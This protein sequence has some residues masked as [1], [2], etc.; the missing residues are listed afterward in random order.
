MCMCIHALFLSC[1]HTHTRQKGTPSEHSH[2]SATML[3]TLQ[4]FNDK[5]S[6]YAWL[7]RMAMA[8][9]TI[10][11]SVLMILGSLDFHAV[12]TKLSPFIFA[13]LTFLIAYSVTSM[14]LVRIGVFYSKST[15]DTSLIAGLLS[16]SISSILCGISL[17]ISHCLVM[18][19]SFID[20]LP[21]IQQYLFAWNSSMIGTALVL[22]SAEAL[23][24]NV[25]LSEKAVSKVAPSAEKTE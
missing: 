10:S 14:W 6:Y 15:S 4:S 9:T 24:F 16:A 5:Y 20:A 21:F 18:F 13:T 8:S 23:L 11:M 17:C 25:F 22:H 1:V 2:E 12:V 7:C 3:D 19:G